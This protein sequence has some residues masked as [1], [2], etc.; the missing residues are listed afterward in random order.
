MRDIKHRMPYKAMVMTF[1][2][3]FILLGGCGQIKKPKDTISEIAY[4]VSKN[5]DCLVY[6]EEGNTFE[7]YLVL[8]SDYGG[9]TLL[10]RKNLLEDTMPYNK[11]ERH[12]WASHE[13]GGYYEDSTIDNFLNTE[14]LEILSSPVKE[15]M[16]SSDIII[17]DKSSLG[18]SGSEKSIISR[19]VFLLSLKELNGAYLYASIPEENVLRFFEDDYN[20]RVAYLPNGDG[21]A[22]WTRTPET[23]ETY[24]VFTIGRQGTGVGSADI[25]SGVRPAFCLDGSTPI[26]Q[27]TDIISGQTVYVIK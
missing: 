2:A 14:F 8:T 7:P 27:R 25:D 12:M 17:T 15:A 10:L 13:Y 21:C 9:N 6:I 11:N 16:V 24:T 18:I 4:N 3:C 5:E 19:K 20:R 22:Y 1:V 23:W 26:V